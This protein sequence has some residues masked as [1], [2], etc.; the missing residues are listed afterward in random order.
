M[1]YIDGISTFRVG[2]PIDLILD[3]IDNKLILKPKLSKIGEASL[4]LDKITNAGMI[5]EEEI[6]EASVVGRA[7]VG[8]LLFGHLGAIIGGMSGT[9]DKK[10]T[11]SYYVIN[12]T[13]NGE[14]KVVS[15]KQN[16]DFNFGKFNKRLCE[17]CGIQK[18]KVDRMWTS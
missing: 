17:I 14:E 2:W 11:Q 9:K 10:K 3:E 7:V 8:G 12:Y 18:V 1:V 6:K 16:G 4:N 15:M 13:S 5:T